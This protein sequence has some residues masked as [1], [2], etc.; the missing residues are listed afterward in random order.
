MKSLGRKGG[1]RGLPLIASVALGLLPS[2][3]EMGSEQR[4]PSMVGTRAARVSRRDDTLGNGCRY[5]NIQQ[6]ASRR[7][8]IG[9][10]GGARQELVGVWGIEAQG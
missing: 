6:L 9:A 8:D 2:P 3:Y 5:E 1:G 7:P 4:R 10:V